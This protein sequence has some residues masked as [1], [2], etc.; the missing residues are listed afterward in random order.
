MFETFIA[1]IHV[2]GQSD[3]ALLMTVLLVCDKLNG[4]VKCCICFLDHGLCSCFERLDIGKAVGTTL[5]NPSHSRKLQL[6]ILDTFW[7]NLGTVPRPR[8]G[9][10][11]G[12]ACNVA[13]STGSCIRRLSRHTQA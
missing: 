11:A 2:S 4:N 10:E 8:Q 5:Y 9:K 12:L 3:Q 7:L 1:K 13:L 6:F